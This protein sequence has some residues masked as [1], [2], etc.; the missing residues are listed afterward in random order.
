MTTIKTHVYA[1]TSNEPIPIGT[2]WLQPIKIRLVFADLDDTLGRG[3]VSE[4][5]AS[6]INRYLTDP[7][8]HFVVMSARA[9]YAIAKALE[10]AHVRSSQR[11]HISGYHS[12]LSYLHTVGTTI[13]TIPLYDAPI[14]PVTV[15]SIVR[16]AYDNDVLVNGVAHLKYGAVAL[17]PKSNHERRD[18]FLD[19]YLGASS[20][21]LIDAPHRKLKDD[22][23]VYLLEF[24]KSDERQLSE[25]K[26]MLNLGADVD[27]Y[28]FKPYFDGAPD[29]TKVLQ[30]VPAGSGKGRA[31]RRYRKH[32]QIPFEKTM[33]I[34]D[35]M[36]DVGMFCQ[37]DNSVAMGQAKLE[38]KL[39]ADYVTLSVLD[40]G[41]AV[42]MKQL[43]L[44]MQD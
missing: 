6:A 42:A 22:E 26:Q 37:V 28:E 44:G 10:N 18:P 21:H 24:L 33:A 2:V 20:H 23:Q 27:V 7:K 12:N 19:W 11:L 15:D 34:G 38:V 4:S 9:P 25:Y 40:D 17:L 36:A 39:L 29:G 30:V 16:A 14:N 8:N 3:C 31:A 41:V 13:G 1:D 35:S 43:V 5:S 32:L